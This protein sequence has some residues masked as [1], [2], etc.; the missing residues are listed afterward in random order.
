MLSRKEKSTTYVVTCN[1][2]FLLYSICEFAGQTMNHMENGYCNVL[3]PLVC[4]LHIPMDVSFFNYLVDFSYQSRVFS[5]TKF[6]I[7]HASWWHGNNTLSA[8]IFFSGR[9]TLEKGLSPSSSFLSL[10]FFLEKKPA[11]TFWHE[12]RVLRTRE[13]LNIKQRKVTFNVYYVTYA[14]LK[15]I[16]LRRLR[17]IVCNKA[18]NSSTLKLIHSYIITLKSSKRQ[19]LDVYFSYYLR[20]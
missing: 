5:L 1:E 18:Q 11:E 9:I 17:S 13:N 20:K 12:T 3:Y 19:L 10:L 2:L 15:D 4:V 14:F 7:L 8:D 6:I 16:R